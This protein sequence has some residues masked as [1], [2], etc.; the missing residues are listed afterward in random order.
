MEEHGS[1][2]MQPGNDNANIVGADLLMNIKRRGDDDVMSLKSGK[3]SERMER[4]PSGRDGRDGSVSGYSEMSSEDNN[5]HRSRSSSKI[6]RIK[7]A[8][9]RSAP[10]YD[11]DD[12]ASTVSSSDTYSSVSSSVDAAEPK[13]RLTQD[14]IMTMKRELLY[15]FDR[16]EKKGIKVP[17]KFNMTSS[18]EE[19][20]AEFERLKCD[21][22][23][24]ISVKFQRK[25]L[26]AIITGVEFLNNKFDPFDFKLDG[27]S[28]NVN[29]S[30][31]E[32][33]EIFEELYSKYRGK[34]KMPPE[35]KL[36][37]MLGGSA[38]MFH[39]SNTMFKSQLPGLDNVLKQNPDLMRH[40]ASATMNTMAS[41]NA[42][43]KAAQNSGGGMGGGMGGLLGSLMGGG[44]GLGGLMNMFMPQMPPQPSNHMGGPHQMGAGKMRGPS[45]VDDILNEL[46]VK[47]VKD[48]RIETMS[49]VSDSD[50]SEI[51][52]DES[53]FS[54][55]AAPKRIV[56]GSG[57]RTLN[58]NI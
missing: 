32:Y 57:A 25:M 53:V 38:F 6:K 15:Q 47:N 7:R 9:V 27:W 2:S 16:L 21:R 26:M 49:T 12:G 4:I 34:A 43:P 22:E 10:S 11:Q 42:A 24:E 5:D 55:K 17:K 8:S 54:N 48:D 56:R 44:G 20:K 1:H 14:D 36:M 29:D 3:G 30:I 23:T 28:E 41:N 37:F 46:N 50:V 45:N 33:D 18:L 51:P 58:L 35:L 19:M 13:K 39:L 31:T 40:V 52:D